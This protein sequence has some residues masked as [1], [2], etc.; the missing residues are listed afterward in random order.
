[1]IHDNFKTT[2]NKLSQSFFNPYCYVSA[3][4]FTDTETGLKQ[5]RLK[6]L[7]NLPKDTTIVATTYSMY[8][9]ESNPL[10]NDNLNRKNFFI[11]YNTICND[12]INKL[13]QKLPKAT[14]LPLKDFHAKLIL[15]EPDEVW[16]GSSN[17]SNSNWMDA[18]VGIKNAK[19][20]HFFLYKLRCKMPFTFNNMLGIKGNADSC[21]EIVDTKQCIKTL[22][23]PPNITAY[24]D[25]AILLPDKFCYHCGNKNSLEAINNDY[26]FK[27]CLCS[28]QSLIIED[29]F[30]DYGNL[31]DPNS[32]GFWTAPLKKCL[33]E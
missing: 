12:K 20:Y 8:F 2:I 6:H 16:I 7:A 32:K 26:E 23:N 3:G 11:I 19:A 13:R 33:S 27:C 31:H 24:H 4:I 30:V 29:N 28:K 1:M 5:Q 18:D 10:I 14:F 22:L 17:L 9:F 25:K 21:Y 15:I